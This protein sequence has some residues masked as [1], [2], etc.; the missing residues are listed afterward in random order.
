MGKHVNGKR[1][2]SVCPYHEPRFPTE[3]RDVTSKNIGGISDLVVWAPIKEGFIDAFGNVTYASRLRIVTEALNK[4]RKNVREFQLSE[5]F[6]DTTKR[7]LSLLDFRI[8]LV[9]RDIHGYGAPD[10]PNKDQLRPREYMYLTATFDG[11]W[12]PYMRQIWDPL[13]P[14]LDVVL[15]NCEGYILAQESSFEDYI[16]WVKDHSL[17]TGMF[18]LV[19]EQTVKDHLYLEEIEK[20]DRRT[21]DHKNRD[22]ATIQHTVP[23]PESESARERK[24]NYENALTL[25]L[26]A[27]NVMYQ[28]T[29]YYP[30]HPGLAGNGKLLWKATRDI[31]AEMPLKTLLETQGR[32]GKP[33]PKGCEKPDHA[34]KKCRPIKKARVILQAMKDQLDWYSHSY[35]RLKT[36]QSSEPNEDHFVQKGLLSSYDD[37]EIAI[38]ASAMLMLKITDAEKAKLFLHPYLWSWE[39]CNIPFYRNLAITMKG[40]EKLPFSSEEEKA[41][42]KEFRQGMEERSPQIGDVYH[43]HPQRWKRPLRNGLMD[44]SSNRQIPQVGL[45][46]VD[47]IVQLRTTNRSKII[48][49]IVGESLIFTPVDDYMPFDVS[50]VDWSKGRD[51]FGSIPDEHDKRLNLSNKK[52][53]AISFA[54]HETDSLPPD[55]PNELNQTSFLAF[56]EIVQKLI[57]QTKLDAEQKKGPGPSDR[58]LIDAYIQLLRTNGSFFG[59]ELLSIQGGYRLG[60]AGSDDNDNTPLDDPTPRD[61]FGFKDGISQPVI[62]AEAKPDTSKPMEIMKGDLILG[63]ANQIG[64][65][66]TPKSEKRIQDNGSFLVVRKMRQDVAAFNDFLEKNDHK[67]PAEHLAAKMMGRTKDGKPLVSGATNNE[68]NYDSDPDGLQC[69]F[70]SHIRRANPRT[71]EHGRKTPKILR[72]GMSYGHR[73]NPKK[74]DNDRGVLFMAYCANI[75][76]QYEL[77]QRWVNGGNSTNI[78]SGQ[79]DPLFG[80]PA[81][82]GPD[83][84]KFPVKTG[85][86]IE[87]LRFHPKK[88]QPFVQLEWGLYAFAPGKNTLIKLRARGA[89]PARPG[90]ISPAKRGANIVSAIEALPNPATKRMSWKTVLEDFTIKDPGEH[91][92]TADIMAYIREHCEGV[93]R[94][95]EGIDGSEDSMSETPVVLV[96]DKDKIRDILSRPDIFSSKTIRS[97]LGNVFEDHY[98]GMDPDRD[99]KS[100]PYLAASWAT[101]EILL[102]YSEKSAFNLGF[103]CAKHILD[104]RKKMAKFLFEKDKYKIELARELF[105]PALAAVCYR[106]FGIPDNLENPEFFQP[107]AF[108]HLQSASTDED[109]L[110]RCPGDFL[111]PSRGSFYPRPTEAI[112]MYAKEHGQKLKEAIAGLSDSWAKKGFPNSSAVITKDI[113]K[114]LGDYT[115]LGHN[116]VGAMIGMLPSSEASLRAAFYDWT[117]KKTLWGIQGDLISL[118]GGAEPTFDQASIAV[119][120]HLIEAMS[121]RPAPDL[122]YRTAVQSG[123]IAGKAYNKD[124]TI[125]LSLASALQNDLDQGNPDISTVFGNYRDKNDPYNTGRNPHACPAMD[126]AMGSLLGIVT[127]LLDAG[128]I[129]AM[130]ASLIFEISSL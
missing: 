95:P 112:A 99:N 55:L 28:L 123:E 77:I 54:N 109:R 46:E 71:S 113:A 110:A 90:A 96:A 60:T 84:F 87:V 5:P 8:G 62:A 92:T 2:I 25:A 86:N 126:M 65:H 98:I 45:N 91:N 53:T 38:K 79:T 3:K 34:C 81:R 100:D 56:G 101:N 27:L 23:T 106:W 74:P 63:H 128:N 24:N 121:K 20:I 6:P 66:R 26:E 80:A 32:K 129:Q 69:P 78:A 17:D 57:Q 18:Y 70:I 64:D 33:L 116:I 88:S 124:D 120:P 130:P 4:L 16:Q 39:G 47:L 105:A 43:N 125:I 82:Q 83:S 103:K 108:P 75:A 118:T 52:I 30:P 13:G 76:E 107:G 31:L 21:D 58:I 22:A 117:D 37:D 104:D 67:Y 42:P 19:T 1:P 48:K 97:R 119:K 7:I 15:C 93:Y 68:F 50:P 12:E 11:P 36:H 114:K 111:A 49:K 59:I 9:E 29:R 35:P 94:I 61:H 85:N 115:L 41:F 10:D 72:R 40:I 127:A 14:F 51:E 44:Y 73:F 102:K 89:K 122:L